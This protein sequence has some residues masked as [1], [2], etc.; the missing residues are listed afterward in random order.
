M[1][2]PAAYEKLPN[3][4]NY[5][6]AIMKDSVKKLSLLAGIIVVVIVF[7]LVSN[8]TRDVDFH[9]KYEGYDLTTDVEGAEREGTYALSLLAHPDGARPSESVEVNLTDYVSGEG[10]EVQKD[11]AGEAQVLYTDADSTVT[12][13]VDVPE[14]GF[15]NLYLEYMTVESRGVPVERAV[16]VNGELPFEKAAN[17]TFLR[18]WKDGGEVRVDNQGN[19]I[20]PTQVE[21]YQ[22][23][24]DYC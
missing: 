11:Y 1:G 23:Q 14:A 20:R 5:M 21:E 19:E 13:N 2:E 17:I 7:I 18:I 3:L 24:G 9:E 16:Y 12:W 4:L 6:E 8:L 15:Y 10:V 22:W